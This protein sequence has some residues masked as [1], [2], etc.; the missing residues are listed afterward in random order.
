[1]DTEDWTVRL[2]QRT[3]VSEL[4]TRTTRGNSPGSVVVNRGAAPRSVRS[5]D[6]AGVESGKGCVRQTSEE[7]EYR[8]EAETWAGRLGLCG[9]GSWARRDGGQGN[10]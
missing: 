7:R 9:K 6:R 10:G 3:A 2:P 4:D 5:L 1:M 8:E